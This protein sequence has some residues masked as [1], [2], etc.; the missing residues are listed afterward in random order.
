[1]FD[2]SITGE[3]NMPA[4]LERP[5]MTKLM[6]QTLKRHILKERERKKQG[7]LANSVQ[8]V[9]FYSWHS[10]LFRFFFN[11]PIHAEVHLVIYLLNIIR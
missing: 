7:E 8:E 5:K 1:M 10:V 3:V 9:P 11:I 6:Y 2:F 4:L